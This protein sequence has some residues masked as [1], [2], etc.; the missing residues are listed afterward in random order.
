MLP[1]KKHRLFLRNRGKNSNLPA[2]DILYSSKAGNK[3][4]NLSRRTF[5]KSASVAASGAM[6]IPGL[7]S[8]SPNNK[9]NIA[10]I[11][12]GG[13][14]HA[15]WSKATNE[16][17]VAMCDV[18]DSRA[19]DGFNQYPG[20]PK[21]KDFR[22]MFDKMANKIDA[23]MISTPDH[24]HFAATMAAIQLGKH[25][26]VEKPLA[27]NIW[28][29]RTLRKAARH[30]NI[31]SQ[32]GN[33]GHTTNGIRLIKEWYEAGVLGQVSEVHAWF[34]PFDF[35]P[36]GYWTK[37]GSYPP[38][39][40][41]VPETLDWNLWLGPQAERPYNSVYVPKA[42]RGFYDFGNGLL[43]DWACHTIDAPFWALNLGMPHTV[44]STAS[45]PLPDHSFI[46]DQSEVTFHFGARGDKV[47]VQLHWHEGG[48]KPEIRPEW[49]VAKLPETGMVMIGD[50]KTLITGGRPNNPHL[51]VPDEEW[52]EFLK[53]APE[54][55][56]PRVGEEQPQQEW[57]DAIKNNTLPGSNFD[58]ATELTEMILVGVLSQRFV[59]K[60]EY[61]AK[62]MKVT[63][64]PDIDAYIKEPMRDGWAYGEDLW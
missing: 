61:D 26:Y 54:K 20:I 24:T 32:M 56:I 50:K 51:M 25:V 58:Y 12:V 15:N 10:V 64:R 55:T 44:E 30:Y 8:C 27:H 2:L 53:N 9:L 42:W 52:Q 21:F 23:V 22:V 43:G 63:N 17:I 6:F 13:R 46:S 1:G 48:L 4:K 31:V 28:Q 37:P 29:L 49:G 59:S 34:G 16:N 7:L 62:N 45:N 11:G 39:A 3:M 60:V 57:I 41:P 36:G 33:Q 14:G 5:L 19:A 47:P 18:D 35:K 38:P 40:Q